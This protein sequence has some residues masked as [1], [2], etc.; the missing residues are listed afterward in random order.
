[1]IK[2]LQKLNLIQVVC[3]L[4][5]TAS[6]VFL[7]VALLVPPETASS[8]PTN[9]HYY[10]P[11][12]ES[13]QE[14]QVNP[15]TDIYTVKEYQGI[16][17]VFKNGEAKPYMTENVQVPLLPAEDKSLITKGVT[18]DSYKEMIRFLQDYE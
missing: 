16:I 2:F 6:L 10:T 4:I 8:L 7:C 17:G 12:K 11:E 18:F 5:M 13:S 1:M 15:Q 3:I 14:T 9:D